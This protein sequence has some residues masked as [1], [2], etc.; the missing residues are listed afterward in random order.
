MKP[1]VA[2]PLALSAVCTLI[3]PLEALAVSRGNMPAYC[4]GEV[5]GQYGTKPMYVKTAKPKRAKDG[6]TTIRGTVDKGSEGIK[7]FECQFDAK[8]NLTGVMA[9]TSDGE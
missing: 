9:L 8:G 7:E 3:L 1:I 4:R 5:S 6:S 2:I